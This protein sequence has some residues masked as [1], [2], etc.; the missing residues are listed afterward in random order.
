MQKMVSCPLPLSAFLLSFGRENTIRGGVFHFSYCGLQQE[1]LTNGIYTVFYIELKCVFN[2]TFLSP[3]ELHN[4]PFP[5]GI[6]GFGYW[7]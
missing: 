4:I 1:I 3:R 5:D 6:P 2:S 7:H